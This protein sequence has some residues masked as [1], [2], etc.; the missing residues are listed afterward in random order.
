MLPK[1]EKERLG[2]LFESDGEF[3]MEYKDFSQQ[4][5]IIEFCHLLPDATEEIHNT[6]KS[7]KKWVTSMF[8]GEWVRGV[9]AGGSPD[10]K[11]S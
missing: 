7:K 3:W 9:S 1:K 5:T 2:V 11:G 4:F 8:N 10:N 6:E